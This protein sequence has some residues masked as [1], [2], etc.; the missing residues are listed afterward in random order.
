MPPVYQPTSQDLLIRGMGDL[1]IRLDQLR[2]E[3]P[4][5]VQ[6]QD[7]ELSIARGAFNLPLLQFDGERIVLKQSNFVLNAKKASV[8]F[9]HKHGNLET[10]TYWRQESH[11]V[12]SGQASRLR[13]QG[14]SWLLDEATFSICPANRKTWQLSAESVK[15]DNGDPYV[16]LVGPALR[17]WGYH[18]GLFVDELRYPIGDARASGWLAPKV[19]INS[20]LGLGAGVPYFYVIDAEQDVQITPIIFSRPALLLVVNH[21]YINNDFF[22][23]TDLYLIPRDKVASANSRYALS[24]EVKSN[25]DLDFNVYGH[26]QRVGDRW[27]TRDYGYIERDNQ[28]FIPSVMVIEKKLDEGMW[29]A[30]LRHSQFLETDQPSTFR[31]DRLPQITYKQRFAL[32]DQMKLAFSS[33]YTFFSPVGN[34]QDD[35]QSG[36]RLNGKV[37]PEFNQDG[38]SGHLYSRWLWHLPEGQPAKLLLV[39]DLQV[40]Q[41]FSFQ[42]QGVTFTPSYAWH[43][44]N[45]KAPVS[46]THLRAH[47]T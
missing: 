23:K 33:Q 19:S 16:S 37:G 39:P 12:A 43:W 15:I 35:V 34:V 17:L 32:T 2:S 6:Y 27:W 18:L 4:V 11:Y 40:Q 20:R 3:S 47:E 24:L 45:S 42:Q 10:V 1:D 22:Y 36:F 46:Y 28:F 13:W 14:Q 30:E 5:V 44:V 31:F 21:R 38:I 8:D 9:K 26:W 29:K 7:Y 41:M 25:P